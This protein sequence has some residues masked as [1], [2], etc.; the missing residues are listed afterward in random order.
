MTKGGTKS[1]WNENK[2]TR[3]MWG[4]LRVHRMNWKVWFRELPGWRPKK[5]ERRTTKNGW[6]SSRNHPRKRHR[7]VT[8][9]P[10][11]GFSS[12]KQFFSLILS[13]SQI[14]GGLNIF[15]LPFPPSPTYR[16]KK[17]KLATQ[18][19]QANSA[20]PGELS[21]PRR[22]RLLPPEGTAFRRTSRKA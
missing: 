21:S 13:D 17:E 1:K 9:A 18:L 12:R 22:A 19:A 4:P 7:S 20:R 15:V 10:Q 3:N 16:E 5:N 6:K 11:L 8:E 2:S 14:P